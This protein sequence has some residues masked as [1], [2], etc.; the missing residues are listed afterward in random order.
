MNGYP[1]SSPGCENAASWAVLSEVAREGDP[2]GWDVWNYTASL[3]CDE[4]RE[5]AEDQA[6]A[7]EKHY[8]LLPVPRSG[9]SSSAYDEPRH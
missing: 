3:A 7:V 5:R 1:C 9:P 6:L 8:R 4:H 2:S